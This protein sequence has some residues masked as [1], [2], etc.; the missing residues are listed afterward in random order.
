MKVRIVNMP[1]RIKGERYLPGTE[2][3]IGEELY[4]TMKSNCIILEESQAKEVT[5]DDVTVEPEKEVTEDDVIKASK[6]YK[7]ITK[8]ELMIELAGQGTEFDPN[9]NKL[10]LFKMLG[11]D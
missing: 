4:K 11:R 7:E 3:D 6:E 10:E 5:E 2:L 1:V 8:D 9:N